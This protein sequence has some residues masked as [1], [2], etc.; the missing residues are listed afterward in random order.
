MIEQFL[1]WGFRQIKSR[2]KHPFPKVWLLPIEE[3]R[4]HDQ[5]IRFFDLGMKEEPEREPKMR[6]NWKKSEQKK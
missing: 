3:G 6:K 5:K 1:I 4:P 2:K